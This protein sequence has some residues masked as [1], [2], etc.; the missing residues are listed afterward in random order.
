MDSDDLAYQRSNVNFAVWLQRLLRNSPEALAVQL[1]ARHCPGR[2][3]TA[4]RLANGAFNVCFRV[5]FE[6]GDQAIVRFTAFG[7]II[8]RNEKTEDEVATMEFVGQHTTIPVPKVFG[9]GKSVPG[10]YIVMSYVEGHILSGYLKDPTHEGGNTLRP[11]ISLQALCKA[12]HAMADV[13]LELSKVEFPFIGAIGK[14]ES[15]NWTV[16]KGPLTLNMN[17]IAQF[18][19]VP[20]K[21]FQRQRF[22]NAADYF[23]ELANHHLHHLEYQRND[24]VVDALDC[25]KKYIARCLFRKV[26]REI[27]S[28]HCNGPF[29]LYCDDLNP[30]NVLI[31]PSKITVAGVIDWEFSYAAPA[32]F[33]YAAPWWLLLERPESWED[34]LNEFMERYLPRF[35]TFLDVLRDCETEK[36]KSGS[37]TESQ[38]LSITMEQSLDN[39]LFWICLASRHSAMFDEIY[40]NIVDPKFFGPLTSI[41]DRMVLL[42]T[43]ERANMDTFVE[44]K[45]VQKQQATLDVHNSAKELFDL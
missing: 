10:P 9:Y 1:A 3:V 21:V 38:R 36:I 6:N 11:N 44:K 42:S 41:E 45:L 24:A 27:S 31:D 35:H 32:E 33:T 18:S 20:H 16:S 28:E 4:S 39:G 14:H 43:E 13:M 26:S 40:W 29:R 22:S 30:G 17:R 19:N 37:L 15:G 23:E 2:P 34:D 7:R 25:Q 12:Y 5:N 8:A